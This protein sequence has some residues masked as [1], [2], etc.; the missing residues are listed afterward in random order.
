MPKTFHQ[1]KRAALASWPPE[2]IDSG[3]REACERINGY[4]GV[5]TTQSC[6]GHR[7][8][9]DEPGIDHV[10]AGCFWLHLHSALRERADSLARALLAHDFIKECSLRWGRERFPVFEVIFDVGAGDAAGHAVTDWLRDSGMGPEMAPPAGCGWMVPAM[11]GS[12][13]TR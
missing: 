8:P 5:Y 1:T 9:T 3:V 6:E 11:R 13:A 7:R 12:E 10:E 2:G 4:R